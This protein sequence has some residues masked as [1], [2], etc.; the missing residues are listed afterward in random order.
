M[1]SE[2]ERRIADRWGVT[3]DELD[4]DGQPGGIGEHLEANPD[5][6]GLLVLV[7]QEDG[8]LEVYA[9]T[10]PHLAEPRREL[11]AQWIEEK[12]DRFSEHGPEPDGW[13]QRKSDGGWQLWA[14]MVWMPPL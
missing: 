5:L 14:R 8:H 12:I 1:P 11:L 13:Q 7:P 9:A 4:L 6:G 2:A 3:L 10:R